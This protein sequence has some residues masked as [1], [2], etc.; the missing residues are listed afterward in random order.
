MGTQWEGSHLQSQEEGSYQ[1]RTM[2]APWSQTSCLR[3]C[4][5][6]NMLFQPISLWYF[7]T[8]AP[9][10]EDAN[11]HLFPLPLEHSA[12]PKGPARSTD[13]PL[14]FPKSRKPHL[15][16]RS[17]TAGHRLWVSEKGSTLALLQPWATSISYLGAYIF[18][19]AS[20]YVGKKA[21]LY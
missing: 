14:N 16:T 11:M 1:N 12:C 10:D 9:A 7:V 21:L 4:E 2:L 15:Q 3:N 6:I 8:A 5:K 19:K 20:L 13:P 17:G 18:N